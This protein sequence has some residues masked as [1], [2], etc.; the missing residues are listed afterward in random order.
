MVTHQLQVRCRP[1]KVRRSEADVLPLSYITNNIEMDDRRQKIPALAISNVAVFEVVANSV[2]IAGAVLAAY[3]RI[4]AKGLR[5]TDV[6]VGSSDARWT[7]TFT[8]KLV[9]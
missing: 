3:Q 5:K 1:G 8:G 2:R 4:K 7:D 6:T 9:T